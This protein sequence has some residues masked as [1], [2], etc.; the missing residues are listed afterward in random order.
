M[1]VLPSRPLIRDGVDFWFAIWLFQT[2]RNFIFRFNKF[3]SSNFRPLWNLAFNSWTLKFWFSFFLAGLNFQ[4]SIIGPLKLRFFDC[5]DPSV[6]QIYEFRAPLNFELLI[7]IFPIFQP[8]HMGKKFVAFFTL[9]IVT[10]K[11][12]RLPTPSPI[13]FLSSNFTENPFHSFH[14][15]HR[16]STPHNFA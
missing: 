13:H 15:F 12:H 16:R 6:S 10:Q 14:S 7:F 1:V 2:S 9:K 3:F 11:P 8:F 5:S 4:C